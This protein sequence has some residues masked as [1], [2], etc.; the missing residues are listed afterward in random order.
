[1]SWSAGALARLGQRERAKECIDRAQSLAPDDDAILYN[2][3]KSLSAS[4]S[5][6]P[7]AWRCV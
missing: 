1:M 4:R 5:D 3:G 6:V 7:Q 2:A